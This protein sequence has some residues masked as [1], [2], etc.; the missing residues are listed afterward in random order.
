[1]HILK[2]YNKYND[3]DFRLCNIPN[4]VCIKILFSCSNNT[5]LS[6]LMGCIWGCNK[7][8]NTNGRKLLTYNVNNNIE[9][10]CSIMYIRD[11]KHVARNK[12]FGRPA[13]ISSNI[14]HRSIMCV[15]NI[16]KHIFCQNSFLFINIVLF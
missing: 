15:T 12:H 7:L 8:T 6:F 13:T 2:K 1:M 3:I 16:L 11:A 14:T 5:S 10:H 4:I 9:Y